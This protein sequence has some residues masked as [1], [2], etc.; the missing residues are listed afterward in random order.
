MKFIYV[1][2][3]L[4]LVYVREL[5]KNECE[6]KHITPWHYSK[7][8]GAPHHLENLDGFNPIPPKI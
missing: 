5:V 7:N 8:D 6:K 4:K 2:E 1:G 3:I